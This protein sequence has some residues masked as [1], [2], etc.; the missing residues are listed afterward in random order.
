MYLPLEATHV[1]DL[2]HHARALLRPR[3]RRAAQTPRE[4][5]NDEQ[6]DRAFLGARQPRQPLQPLPRALVFPAGARM[7]FPLMRRFFGCARAL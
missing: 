5:P 6:I 1:S 3:R 7:S 4:L 2:A